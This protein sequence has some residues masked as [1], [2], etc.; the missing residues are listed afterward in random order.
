MNAT[1]QIFFLALLLFLPVTVSAA[2]V[3]FHASPAYIGAG[4][5]V[6]VTVL[7]DSAIPA[8]AFSGMM[9]YSAAT[10]EPI[11]VSDGNSIISLWITNPA[12]SATGAPITF[13]GITPGG[14]SGNSGTLFSILFRAKTAGTARVSIQDAEVLRNDGAGG[15]EPVTVKPLTL[16]VGSAPIGGYVEPDETIPPE[17]FVASLGNDPQLFGG[18]W[19]LAFTAVDKGSGIDY[20]AVAESRVPLFL[21]SLFPLSWSITTSPYAITD[22]N[23][24]STV[25]IKAIDRAGN[26]RVSIYPPRHFLT[27]YEITTLLVILIAVAL[28]YKRRQGRRLAHNS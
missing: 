15:N 27:A 10:L 16:P 19:Y 8:N 1:K 14:F 12:I 3:S 11:D 24:T 28:L 6:L 9:S 22:Q 25:Y 17:V 21:L 23:L 18:R 13:A 2:T 7:I 20:Y 26:E 5:E 4:D